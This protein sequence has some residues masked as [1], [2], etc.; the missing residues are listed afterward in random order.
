VANEVKACF[1]E[2]EALE[3]ELKT[4]KRR[5]PDEQATL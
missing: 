2:K 4:L 5:L 3:E 1:G